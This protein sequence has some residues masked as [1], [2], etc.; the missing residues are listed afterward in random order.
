MFVVI[1]LILKILIE[2]HF[3]GTRFTE[4]A[5]TNLEYPRVIVEM[6]SR[7]LKKIY[8]AKIR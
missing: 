6:L 4:I 7:N 8:T 3:A 5:V 1:Y 2:D